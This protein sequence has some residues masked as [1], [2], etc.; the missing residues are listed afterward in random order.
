[1]RVLPLLVHADSVRIPLPDN[2]VHMVATSPPYFN[3][4]VYGVAPTIWGGDPDCD[5]DWDTGVTA[6]VRGRVG[7]HSSLEGGLAARGDGRVQRMDHGCFCKRCAAWLGC[8]GQ[9]P[10]PDQFV[11]HLRTICREVRRVLRPDGLFWLNLGFTYAANRGYQVPDSNSK[12]K[13][14]GN[15]L[16]ARVPT[17]YKSKDLIA[18]PWL[19]GLALQQDGWWLRSAPPWLNLNKLPESVKDRLTTAHEYWLMFSKSER[20]YFDVD[21]IRIPYDGPT[22]RW[23]GVIR[24]DDTE[25]TDSY[26]DEVLGGVGATS[27]FQPGQSFRPNPTGRQMRTSD[28]WYLGLDV[29]I[30]QMRSRLH[31]LE[32]YRDLRRGMLLNEEGRPVA[33]AFPTKS[34]HGAHFATYSPLMLEP[35]IKASTSECGCCQCGA[36][37]QRVVEKG[38]TAHDGQTQSKYPEGT[39]ANRMALLRQAARERGGEYVNTARTVGWRPSCSCGCPDPVPAIVLDPFV[40]SGS[41]LVMAGEL[42][43][44]G[45]GLDWSFDYLKKLARPRLSLDALTAWSQGLA[46]QVSVDEERLTELPLFGNLIK[47]GEHG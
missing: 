12:W 7:D 22:N 40:G 34:Y 15:S 5:H 39:T 11:D 17:G 4:R 41:T 45:I 21:A 18:I 23:G 13:D 8:L 16:S 37:W 28:F 26:R 27:V 9:E 46:K 31:E 43:R 35:I 30:E 36:P 25:K 42:G 47:E 24:W 29:A 1:M 3:M 6:H 19:V 32:S 14:V 44:R 38:L 10:H 2:S 20:Y 33:V